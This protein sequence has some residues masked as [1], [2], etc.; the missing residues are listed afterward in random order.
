[1]T[2]TSSPARPRGEGGDEAAEP[3]AFET[4]A[5]RRL[6]E[7]AAAREQRQAE[8]APQ[9]RSKAKAEPPAVAKAKAEPAPVAKVEPKPEPA[10]EPNT[11]AAAQPRAVERVVSAWPSANEWPARQVEDEFEIPAREEPS[12]REP[13]M[14]PSWAQHPAVPIFLIALAISVAIWLMVFWG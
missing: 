10:P 6:L 4:P 11:D 2:D 13:L 8:Q 12:V 7:A 14:W 1:M 5:L 3:A 9:R